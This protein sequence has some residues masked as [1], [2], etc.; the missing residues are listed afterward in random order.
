MKKSFLIIIGLIIALYIF[1]QGHNK[2]IQETTPTSDFIIHN[3]GTVTHKKTGLMWKVASEGQTWSKGE[4]SGSWQLFTWEETFARAEE[5]NKGKTGQ[6]HGYSDWR[7]PTIKELASI[8]E[9][10]K[11]DQAI[12]SA[13]FP[14]T[15]SSSYWS[16]T[17]NAYNSGNAWEINF[18]DGNDSYC[19]KEDHVYTLRLVRSQAQKQGEIK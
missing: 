8:V 1:A 12:N 14:N 13:V 11:Y 9:Y 5:V 19:S 10:A 17:A 16:A 7:V 4:V 2:N 18:S 15:P 3:N 6:K